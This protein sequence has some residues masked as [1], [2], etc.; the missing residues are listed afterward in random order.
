MAK[1]YRFEKDYTHMVRDPKTG[2]L[3]GH[4]SYPAG[5]EGLLKD[6]HIEGADAAQAGSV[7]EEDGN[8]DKSSSRKSKAQD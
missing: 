2:L 8:G 7:I 4:V 5:H 3:T 6:E 1:R